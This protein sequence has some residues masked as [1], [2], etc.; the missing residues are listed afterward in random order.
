MSNEKRIGFVGPFST[1]NFG[2][3]AMLVNNIYDIN[4]ANFTIFTY[5][6]IFPQRS[7]KKYCDDLNVDYVEVKLKNDDMSNER[8]IFLTPFDSMSNLKNS[9][10]IYSEIDKLDVLIISGGG[11]INHFWMEGIEKINKIMIPIYI[12]KQKNKKIIF[13]ANGIGPFD[14]TKDFYRYFFSYIEGAKIAVRDDFVSM[15]HLTEIGVEKKDVYHIP[16]D[17]YIINERLIN[18]EL[19]FEVPKQEYIVFETF[20]SI[21]QLKQHEELIVQFSQQMQKKYGLDIV[22]LPFDLVHYGLDQAKYL[23]TI[24]DNSVL[25][26]IGEIGYLP[27]QDSYNL[28]KNAKMMITSRYHG[29]VLSL[30]VET[31]V[32]FRLYYKN[33]DLRYSYNKGLGMLRTA[34]DGISYNEMDFLQS[35]LGSILLSVEENFMEI[36]SRQQKIYS[37]DRFKQNKKE[38]Q[39]KRSKYLRD[40]F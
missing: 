18:K 28:I 6:A 38:L 26:N 40:I 7:L 32:I 9:D 17:L 22:L 25:I 34:L 4:C 23:S 11:W 3:W 19:N 16:D 33:N 35:D 30:N 20:Y 21:E 10:E 15:S 12:A 31:P 36:I 39:E 29:L 24:I 1:A 14:E 2:D 5:S 13:T 8:N 37:L 27:I